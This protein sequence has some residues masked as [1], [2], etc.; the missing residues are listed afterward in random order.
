MWEDVDKL[1]LISADYEWY[2]KCQLFA[3]R[4]MLIIYQKHEIFFPKEFFYTKMGLNEL[5]AML[6]TYLNLFLWPYTCLYLA[7]V[8]F[9]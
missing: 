7:D 6:A 1:R 5:Y 2:R 9:L 8:C 4:K 3:N